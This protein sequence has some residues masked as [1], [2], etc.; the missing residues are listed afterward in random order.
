MK[1]SIVEFNVSSNG[2]NSSIVNNANKLVMRQH[3]MGFQE[4]DNQHNNINAFN[5][6]RPKD[7]KTIGFTQPSSTTN[8][9]CS[10]FT[11]WRYKDTVIHES[12]KK[13][14]VTNPSSTPQPAQQQVSTPEATP[15]SPQFSHQSTPS[16]CNISNSPSTSHSVSYSQDNFAPQP[17][18]PTKPTTKPLP[19]KQYIFEENN[20]NKDKRPRGRK[21]KMAYSGMKQSYVEFPVNL[22]NRCEMPPDVFMY[23]QPVQQSKPSK[24]RKQALIESSEENDVAPILLSLVNQGVTHTASLESVDCINTKKPCRTHISISDLL[25]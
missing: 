18:Q 6:Q 3:T 16:T 2:D 24:K 21:P 19:I 12:K 13:R 4:C 25:N 22:K 9:A 20:F 10:S 5:R 1:L 17:T 15:Q 14:A 8:T 11:Y 7:F 23:Q